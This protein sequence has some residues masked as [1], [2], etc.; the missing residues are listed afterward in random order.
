[1]DKT[2]EQ[3]R[4]DNAERG[5]AK[6]DAGGGQM[7]SQKAANSIDTRTPAEERS[8]RDPGRDD[9]PELPEDDGGRV[10]QRR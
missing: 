2:P 9:K 8:F 1:M 7:G 5:T 3:A 6:R 10:K 4:R